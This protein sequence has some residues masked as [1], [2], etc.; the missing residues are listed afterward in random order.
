M[1][2]CNR[3]YVSLYGLICNIMIVM[4]L[5]LESKTTSEI[6]IYVLHAIS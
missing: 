4:R 3:I 2:A 5:T 1:V 6:A